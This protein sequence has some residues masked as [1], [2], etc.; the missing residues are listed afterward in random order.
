M[1]LGILRSVA[2]RGGKIWQLAIRDEPQVELHMTTSTRPIFTL[3]LGLLGLLA[4]CTTPAKMRSGWH[5][6][7]AT[8]E[9][10]SAAVGGEVSRP[11]DPMMPGLNDVHPPTMITLGVAFGEQ[12]LEVNSG[13]P[14][15]P[16]AGGVFTSST[17]SQRVRLRAEHYFESG[18]GVFFEGYQGTA[19]GID[20][21][22]VLVGN[23][24]SSFDSQGIFLAAAFRATIDDDFRLP[25][26]FGA[27]MQS[28]EQDRSTF[29]DGAITRDT[30][31]VRLSAEPEFIFMQR[32]NNG[33]IS[34][35]TG[36]AEVRAGAGPT[37][38]GDNVDSEEGYSFTLDYEFGLRYKFD[39][40]LLT[41]LSWVGSKYHVGTTESYNNLVFFGVDDDFQGVMLT[42]GY[43]F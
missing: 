12:T 11:Q 2:W 19:D 8:F 41:S 9:A 38:V 28:T 36:F 15:P 21:D 32:N 29:T 35:F 7:S 20:D 23:P 40:G 43:R 34:E 24:S 37:D 14:A 27:F 6:E 17:S 5:S 16:P 25:V 42:A 30:M 18:I 33:K 4:S 39:F 10:T 1:N 26:R 3:S 22:L 13:N 31:G